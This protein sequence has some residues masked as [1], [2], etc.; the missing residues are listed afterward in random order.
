MSAK[1]GI[2]VTVLAL[3]PSS[4][5]CFSFMQIL[6]LLSFS[7]TVPVCSSEPNNNLLSRLINRLHHRNPV[8]LLLIIFLI[9]ANR[10][11]P[12]NP[13]LIFPTYMTKC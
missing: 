5:L 10:I 11:D 13:I 6:R 8:I 7:K 3:L 2:L 4:R 12:H 9:E 1:H